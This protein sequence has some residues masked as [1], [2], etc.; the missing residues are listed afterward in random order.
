MKELGPFVVHP[1]VMTNPQIFAQST[2][3]IG[4]GLLMQDL[5]RNPVGL[6]AD[7]WSI[8]PDFLTWTFNLHKGVQFHQGYGEMTAEDVVW[9]M[10]GFATSSH[11]RAGQLAT[12]WEDRAGSRSFGPY[13]VVVNT[14]YPEID[15]LVM[16]WHMT[17]G[18]LSTFIASKKQTEELGVEAASGQ[19]AA[20][21]PWEIVEH[22]SGEFWKM[23]A[24]ENHWRQTPEFAE[25]VF[26]EIP[27]ESA[28]IAGF[29][30]GQLDTFLMSFEAIPLVE[31]VAG[32]RLMSTPNLIE[33]RLR[34][35]GNW[36]PIPGV[37][38]RPGY[39]PDLP[40]VSASADLESREWEEARKVRQALMMAIDRQAILDTTIL[41]G[42]G[43]LNTPLG[44]YSGFEDY[45]EGWD[46]PRYDPEGA[47]E[48]L[49]EARYPDG[50]RITLTTARRGAPAEQEGCEVVA[51][52]RRYK[53]PEVGP[54]TQIVG[55]HRDGALGAAYS[56]AGG[57]AYELP[58]PPRTGRQ[59]HCGPLAVASGGTTSL[60]A[61]RTHPFTV[62]REG[63]CWP[64]CRGPRRHIPW[65]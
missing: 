45:L 53:C 47:R 63:K 37:E 15:V 6:L 52:M 23:A 24:V 49:A 18:R 28:R 26:W 11:P 2:A 30:A 62:Y 31:N 60:G 46:W 43:H 22:R 58:A 50:F 19:I 8:S 13:T 32:A 40:W 33:Q 3:P 5:D 55:V 56:V 59:A 29:Q 16:S 65:R 14:G 21:G 64:C 48:L 10:Q 27:E 34:F 54:H 36:Y 39:D 1:A 20:T 35:Y 17:P 61:H 4:E 25:L 41:S 57:P 7:S 51:Q 38:T 9:S 44:G 12:F 42:Y